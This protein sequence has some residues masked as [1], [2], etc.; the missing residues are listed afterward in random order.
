MAAALWPMRPPRIK[1]LRQEALFH[2]VS[3]VARREDALD[4]EGRDVLWY[5]IRRTARFSGVKIL[6]FAIM[7]EHYGLLVRV[8]APGHISER[9]VLAR[10][11]EFYADRPPRLEALKRDLEAG[12]ERSSRARRHAMERMG[13]VSYFMKE[14][15]QRFTLWHNSRR[16]SIG[17]IWDTRFRSVWVEDT[18]EARGTVAAYVDL[19]PVRAG[20]VE[21]PADYPW[22]GFAHALQGNTAAQAGI[23]DAMGAK[24]WAPAEDE[25]RKLLFDR[26]AGPGSTPSEALRKANAGQ[27]VSIPELLRCPLHQL[28]DGLVLGTPQFVLTHG[29]RYGAAV[30]LQRPIQPH[31][32]PGLRLAVLR[33]LRRGRPSSRDSH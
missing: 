22:C 29:A 28:T 12:G 16:N 3:K 9:E 8:P 32:I 24:A 1:P 31:P 11:V 20:L 21:D 30:S 4:K 27:P 15:K 23:M 18:L 33:S 10:C 17:T 19:N 2:C 25:Y 26:Q 13:D 5:Q 6:T 14:V 7:P